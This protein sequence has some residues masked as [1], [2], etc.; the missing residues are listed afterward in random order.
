MEQEV[1]TAVSAL[2]TGETPTLTA[3]AKEEA[4]RQTVYSLVADDDAALRY[5]GGSIRVCQEQKAVVNALEGLPFA[6]IKGLAAAIYYPAPLRRTMGDIDVITTPAAF[7]PACDALLAAGFTARDPLDGNERHVHFRRNGVTVELHRRFAACN[8]RE[9]E[10]LLDGWIYDALAA[11]MPAEVEGYA[12]PMLPD[13]LNG[14][15]LLDHISQHLESGLGLRQI[16][17]WVMYVDRVLTDEWWESFREK[18][19]R[20]GLTTL[21]VVSARIG[22]RRLGA[23]PRLNW[24]ASHDQLAEDLLGYIFSC[25]NFGT[26]LGKK[27]AVTMVMSQGKGNAFAHLQ[28]RGEENWKALARHPWL[29]PLAWLYQAGR[30]AHRALRRGVSAAEWKASYEASKKRN[31]LIERLGGLQL[32]VREREGEKPRT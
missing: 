13:E 12:F 6:V 25:G 5:I 29:K 32:S 23:Y 11:P 30:Y 22:Q 8:T 26:K 31:E 24:C 15:V 9:Q 2:F 4:V 18:T 7:A 20:L 17:D 14:L 10:E 3:A 16:L 21:A 27:A 19:D 28:K 1:L